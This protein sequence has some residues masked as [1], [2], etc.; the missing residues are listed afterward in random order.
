L[1]AAAL[2]SPSWKSVA[3]RDDGLEREEDK[4]HLLSSTKAELLQYPL[5]ANTLNHQR[6][7]QGRTAAALQSP[8]SQCQRDKPR[9]LQ[10]DGEMWKNSL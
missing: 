10:Q 6:T 4:S 1:N 5:H 8:A 2:S 7:G 3:K 9:M